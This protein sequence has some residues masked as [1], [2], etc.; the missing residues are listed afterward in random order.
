MFYQKGFLP[1]A[2]GWMEQPVKFISAMEIIDKELNR[3]R[4]EKEKEQKRQGR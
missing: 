2:G 1:N 3:I 4:T